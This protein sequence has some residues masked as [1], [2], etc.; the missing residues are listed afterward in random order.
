MK[1]DLYTKAVLGIIAL[2]LIWICISG[3]TP[4]A[5]AQGEV[6][7]VMIVDQNGTPLINA[8]GLR[9]NLGNQA[10]PISLGDQPVPVALTGI[11]RIGAWQPIQVEVLKAPSVQYPGK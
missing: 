4:I 2:C 8:Q 3:I 1:T 10:V 9:V 5:S 6:Q 11:E 7:K